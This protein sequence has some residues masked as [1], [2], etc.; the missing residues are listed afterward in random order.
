[1]NEPEFRE[2]REGYEEWKKDRQ[3]RERE[4][5]AA[6]AA[7][8]LKAE[9][10]DYDDEAV[11][12][13]INA[14]ESVPKKDGERKL[15]E[16]IHYALVGMTRAGVLE[17]RKAGMPKRPSVPSTPGKSTTGPE[18]SELPEDEQ[19]KEIIRRLKE[20]PESEE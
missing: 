20:I 17:Q 11:T 1:M 15:R 2:Q 10:G 16:I 13:F 3:A 18:L 14:L 19:E 6:E 4:R 8:A 12:A 7:R 9:I 5:T